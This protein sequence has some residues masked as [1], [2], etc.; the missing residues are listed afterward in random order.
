MTTP[1]PKSATAPGQVVPER[2]VQ[3]DAIKMLQGFGCVVHRRNVGAM[4]GEHKGK[5]WHVRFS[6][7]GASDLYA[8]SPAGF[9]LECE[10][11]RL[12]ERPSLDQVKWLIAHNGIGGAAAFWVDNVRT[13]ELVYRHIES[14]GRVVYLDTIRHYRVKHRGKSVKVAGPS[15]DFDLG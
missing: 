4:S 3:A 14:G 9:H 1:R 8:I 6:E 11:K 12:G 2:Q 10:I 7:K 5:S 13:L 15:G